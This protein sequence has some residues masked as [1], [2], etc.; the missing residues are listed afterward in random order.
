MRQIKLILVS[1]LF[2]NSIAVAQTDTLPNRNLEFYNYL[3]NSK[4]YDD[5]RVLL[6]SND[7]IASQSPNNYNYCMGWYY[8]NT[9]RLDS[10]A[11]FFRK[12]NPTSNF[13]N[14]SI[15]WATY[16]LMH[17]NQVDDAI[18]LITPVAF[19][20]SL[21]LALKNLELSGAYLLN[22]NLKEFDTFSSKYTYK[23]YDLSKEE[24]TLNNIYN[25]I[26]NFKQKSPLLAGLLSAIVPGLGKI[27]A[28][29]I[30]SG[31]SAFF[32]VSI[33]GSITIENINKNGIKS[34]SSI[35]TGTLFLM[36]YSANIYGSVYSVKSYRDEFNEM[37]D[38]RIKFNIH[39][40]IRNVFN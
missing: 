16:S 27:Y 7:F 12:V 25:D 20:D 21:L 37:V 10:T 32:T 19:N 13:Y 6:K 5:A 35:A 23:Y 8:Y 1:L 39:I 30:G 17:T 11:T 26:Y 3:I 31:F 33:L 40:P 34:V 14:K 4:L 9:N 22:R 2:L 24:K 36:A 29:K 18:Q 38:Y 28:K 15:F